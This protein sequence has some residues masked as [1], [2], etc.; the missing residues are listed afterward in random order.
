MTHQVVNTHL[1]MNPRKEKKRWKKVKMTTC[2]V[3]VIVSGSYHWII[4]QSNDS[5]QVQ[6][7]TKTKFGNPWR[8]V[9]FF[10][11]L[12]K[13]QR[14]SLGKSLKMWNGVPYVGHGRKFPEWHRFSVMGRRGPH[15]INTHH[16]IIF[17]TLSKSLIMV[18]ACQG[19]VQ[20]CG[21]S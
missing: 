21:R 1:G 13:M 10:N 7:I 14:S 8:Q 16:S 11:I 12:F 15:T 6:V 5:M 9:I 2:R 3:I 18:T 19:L 20:C 4:M 17:R